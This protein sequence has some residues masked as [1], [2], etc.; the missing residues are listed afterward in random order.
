MRFP[1]SEL[2]LML[3]AVTVLHK[4]SELSSQGPSLCSKDNEARKGRLC[5][6]TRRRKPLPH[7]FNK[8][9]CLFPSSL[10]SAHL[11]KGKEWSVAT[12]QLRALYLVNC[13]QENVL[14]AP[15]TQG[16]LSGHQPVLLHKDWTSKGRNSI[17]CGRHVIAKKVS[18]CVSQTLRD[19]LNGSVLHLANWSPTSMHHC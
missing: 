1:C 7:L 17:V 14:A 13:H 19:W 12:P 15:C 10:F 16:L 5:K 3:L 11:V 9:P 6:L 8:R 4:H 2:G 18:A